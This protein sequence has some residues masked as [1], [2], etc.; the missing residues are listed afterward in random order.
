MHILIAS[1][2]PDEL[3]RQ[4]S[5]LFISGVSIASKVN[6][7]LGNHLD[8]SNEVLLLVNIS[9]KDDIT[10]MS[11]LILNRKFWLGGLFEN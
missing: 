3:K 2:I 5:I 11:E 9:H 6:A 4:N 7:N 10:N 1:L 8:I